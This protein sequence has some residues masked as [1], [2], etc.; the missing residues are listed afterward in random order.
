MTA[1]LGREEVVRAVH[2]AI[3]AILPG[4]PPDRISHQHHLR[5]LGADSVDRVEIVLGILDRLGL[6]EPMASFSGL[7]SIGA[8]VDFL[9]ARRQA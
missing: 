9:C 5:D 8:L 6:D 2:G 7:P 1:P 3:V 4:L